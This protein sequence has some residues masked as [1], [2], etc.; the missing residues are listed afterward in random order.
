[1]KSSGVIRGVVES[2]G[3]L[4]VSFPVHDGYF[5]LPLRDTA[6]CVQIRD[7]YDS[8]TEISFTFDREL[9]ILAVG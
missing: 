6:M 7:A 5:R 1:M 8:R 2:Q 9:K 3:T 4:L